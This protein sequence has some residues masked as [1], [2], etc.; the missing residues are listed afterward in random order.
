ML[1]AISEWIR[2]NKSVSVL[3]F[4]VKI[5]CATR[6]GLTLIAKRSDVCLGQRCRMVRLYMRQPKCTHAANATGATSLECSLNVCTQPTP[7]AQPAWNA[8]L[9]RRISVH[10]QQ[11]VCDREVWGW[12][13]AYQLETWWCRLDVTPPPKFCYNKVVRKIGCLLLTLLI[14]LVAIPCLPW[15]LSKWKDERTCFPRI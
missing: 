15:W 1:L 2:V 14:P 7:L 12:G 5:E 9:N 8:Y 11:E 3:L 4:V 10:Q 13:V 6:L